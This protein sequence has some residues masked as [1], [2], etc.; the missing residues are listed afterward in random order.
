MPVLNTQHMQQWFATLILS[1]AERCITKL[2]F[3]P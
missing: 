2:S 3:T 1:S